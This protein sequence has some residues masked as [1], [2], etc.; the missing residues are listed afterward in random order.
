M[1]Y[2]HLFYDELQKMKRDTLPQGT[3][4]YRAQQ[5][6]FKNWKKYPHMWM[7]ASE[8]WAREYS[9]TRYQNGVI[10]A[11]KTS[12][13]LVLLRATAG[14]YN[15]CEKIYGLSVSNYHC[16]QDVDLDD[17]LPVLGKLQGISGIVTV[18]SYKEI[19]IHSP[20]IWLEFSSETPCK[21]M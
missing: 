7:S 1:E 21:E 16:Q 6:S 20:T 14:L 13:P 15:I 3:Q 4:L 12:K 10:G 19:L 9:R 17:V 18:D 8:E 5:D 2:Q 11:F